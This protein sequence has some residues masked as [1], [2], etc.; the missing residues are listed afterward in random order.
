MTSVDPMTDH[1][2]LDNVVLENY[3]RI[4]KTAYR[5]AV[6]HGTPN[7]E[8]WAEDLTQEVFLRLSEHMEKDRLR[9]HENIAGWL[10]TVLR[11]LI[12]NAWRKKSEQE[13]PVED[14]WAYRTQP[15]FEIMLTEELFPPGLTADERDILYRCK[16]L[17]LSH[18]EVAASLGITTEACRARLHRAEKRFKKLYAHAD[19]STAFDGL[20][21]KTSATLH[22]GGGQNV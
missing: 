4:K 3:A 7:P 20:R 16:V 15:S 2:W 14:I 9:E 12:G 11:N 17:E 5:R 1:E 18:K 6:S 10:F 19:Q 8:Q 22:K 13:I 21:H